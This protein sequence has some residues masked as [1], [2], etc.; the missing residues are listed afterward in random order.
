MRGKGCRAG[1]EVQWQGVG[2]TRWDA[3]KTMVAAYGG[4]CPLVGLICRIIPPCAYLPIIAHKQPAVT[5]HDLLALFPSPGS[6]QLHRPG[7]VPTGQH[8]PG[9]QVG[10]QWGQSLTGRAAAHGVEHAPLAWSPCEARH[11]CRL[12][13]TQPQWQ[14]TEAET[15]L[16]AARSAPCGPL[17]AAGPLCVSRRWGYR[18]RWLRRRCASS[19]ATCTGAAC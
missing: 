5:L 14:L 18:W 4:W 7:G 11:A 10:R 8:G 19:T 15:P 13:S 9:A 17:L 2:P 1:S 16:V 6:S 12:R 3:P